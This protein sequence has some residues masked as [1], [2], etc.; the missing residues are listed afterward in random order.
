ML[1]IR[2]V[3]DIKEAAEFIAALNSKDEH[4]VGYLGTDQ[5][6]ILDSL[7]NEFSELSLED[8]LICAYEEG[9]LI[10]ILGFDYDEEM[11]A[12]EVWGPFTIQM[13][14]MDLALKMW[15]TLLKQ[16]PVILEKVYG[17]YN[18]KN[19]LGIGLMECMEAE[20]K[21][22]QSILTIQK[23]N[24]LGDESTNK[25][26]KEMTTNQHEEFRSLHTATFGDTYFSAGAIVEKLDDQNKVFIAQ[27]DQEFIGYVFCETN[28]EFGEGDIHYIAVSPAARGKGIGKQLI[29]KSL[30]FMFSFK[31]I[32]E[33][34]LC[35]EA[36]NLP[37]IKT[38]KKAGFTE[39]Y[40]LALYM[41]QF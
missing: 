15:N 19:E 37:A 33:I 10:G 30:E 20:R 35:V 3:K 18:V 1:E 38:Y 32:R 22:N 25:T 24:H 12:A 34:T 4:H 29:H 40:H 5:E 16:L 26:I 27:Y 2:K 8:S 23:G 7:L 28:I 14:G 41:V 21:D 11:K 13:P 17:F 31:E 39:K 36:N 9:K 6:E